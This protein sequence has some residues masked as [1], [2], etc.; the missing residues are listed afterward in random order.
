MRNRNPNWSP[1][2]LKSVKAAQDM[3]ELKRQAT[4]LLVEQHGEKC[5]GWLARKFRR[6]FRTTGAI[7][8]V[9]RAGEDSPM[10][11]AIAMQTLYQRPAFWMVKCARKQGRSQWTV[12][13]KPVWERR[14][15]TASN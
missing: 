9:L 13:W 6:N 3:D 8:F 10:W 14:L 2:L 1:P 15:K 4:D 12:A 5:A 7:N 11:F